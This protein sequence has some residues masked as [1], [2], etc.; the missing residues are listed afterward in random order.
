MVL[1][2]D[3]IAMLIPS[4]ME[5][6][7]TADDHSIIEALKDHSLFRIIRPEDAIGKEETLL[8]ANALTD[9]IASGRIDHLT[10]EP[11]KL[12]RQ[13]AF[14]SLSM[15]RLGYSGDRPLAESIVEEL[16]RRG[17]AKDSEDGASIPIHRTVRSLIL[18]LLAQILRSNRTQ[19]GVTLSPI[20]DQVPLVN[21]LSEII[22][23][24]VSPVPSIADVI[25]FDMAMVSADLGVFPIDE[26]LD[27]R[28]QYHAEHREYCLSA[29]RFARELSLMHPEERETAFDERQEE[30][31]VAAQKLKKIHRRAWKKPVSVAIGL[32]GAAWILQQGDP[33]GATIVGAGA[34]FGAERMKRDEVGVYSYLYSAQERFY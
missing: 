25:S 6:Y 4:Y 3:G 32:A 18:V 27:F 29:R 30:L 7:H 26:I 19:A 33:I 17:L 12:N 34:I 15:S 2:F 10:K 11:D 24:P 22:S 9:I 14:G 21:A 13:S 16:K 23:D 20:T 8:L 28:R 5:E 1:F 31:D